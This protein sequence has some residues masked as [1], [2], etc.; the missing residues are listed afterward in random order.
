MAINMSVLVCWVVTPC[1]HVGRRNR[2]SPSTGLEDGDS[3][4]TKIYKLT[5]W[6]SCLKYRFVNLMMGTN[7]YVV[8]CTSLQFEPQ[9][10]LV[11]SSACI[12]HNY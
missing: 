12:S 7:N 10:L 6:V 9:I 3:I 5:C 1:R 8:A 4:I 11:L 2:L